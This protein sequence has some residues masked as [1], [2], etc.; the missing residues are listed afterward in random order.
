MIK[1]R[2]NRLLGRVAACGLALSLLALSSLTLAQ[3]PLRVG[4]YNNPPKIQIDDT[5]R[6]SGIPGE[7]LQE[8]AARESWR[9]VTVPCD[10]HACLLLL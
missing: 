3:Q 1:R 9:L 5:G 6:L 4:A 8:I 7:L 10:W 2:G